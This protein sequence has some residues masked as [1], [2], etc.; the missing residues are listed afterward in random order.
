MVWIILSAVW[1]KLQRVCSP[2]IRGREEAAL[3]A[4]HS[5][6]HGLVNIRHVYEDQCVKDSGAVMLRPWPVGCG[7]VNN[8]TLLL[9][10]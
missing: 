7:L 4:L 9:E 3:F 5:S 6:R 2:G 8:H 10:T 1:C